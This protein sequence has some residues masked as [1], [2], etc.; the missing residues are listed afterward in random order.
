MAQPDILSTQDRSTSLPLNQLIAVNRLS[1]SNTLIPSLVFRQ[2]VF[3]CW[4]WSNTICCGKHEL[5]SHVPL[6]YSSSACYLTA[7]IPKLAYSRPV[8]REHRQG[9]GMKAAGETMQDDRHVHQLQSYY[10]SFT[11][12][13]TCLVH[14]TDYGNTAPR[15]KNH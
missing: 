6:L 9:P 5:Q 10:S 8:S 4:F 1:F 2:T 7:K 12:V 13:R 11:L 14:T 15:M 3:F